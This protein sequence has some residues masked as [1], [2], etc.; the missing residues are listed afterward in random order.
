MGIAFIVPA[1]Y[2]VAIFLGCVVFGTKRQSPSSMPGWLLRWLVWSQAMLDAFRKPC[3][4]TS[5]FPL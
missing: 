1:Y 4:L 5:T 2:S 3:F